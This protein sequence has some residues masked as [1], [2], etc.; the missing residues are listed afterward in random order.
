MLRCGA[1]A[2]S[3]ISVSVILGQRRADREGYAERACN[4]GAE[5]RCRRLEAI[6]EVLPLTELDIIPVRR[7]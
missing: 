4:A 3:Q 5:G 1:L 2:A 6:K 7:T